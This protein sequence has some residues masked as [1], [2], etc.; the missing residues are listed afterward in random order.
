MMNIRFT[1]DEALYNWA[2]EVE[3]ETGSANLP[4]DREIV[5]LASVRAAR[6]SA[7]LKELLNIWLGISEKMQVCKQNPTLVR[8]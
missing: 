7:S 4:D 1:L 5:R 6:R 3:Q 8:D 2:E